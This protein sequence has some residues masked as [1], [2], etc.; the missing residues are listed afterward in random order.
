MPFFCE[1]RDC[2]L[3]IL[4]VMNVFFPVIKDHYMCKIT[5]DLCDCLYNAK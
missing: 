2:K 4:E 3:E 1:S 5:G